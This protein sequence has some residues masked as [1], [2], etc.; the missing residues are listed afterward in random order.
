VPVQGAVPPTASTT[1][2]PGVAGNPHVPAHAPNARAQ[3][4]PQGAQPGA[5]HET[6][7]QKSEDARAEQRGNKPPVDVPRAKTVAQ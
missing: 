5:A 1:P 7:Q 2:A 6:Q 3:P 4:A